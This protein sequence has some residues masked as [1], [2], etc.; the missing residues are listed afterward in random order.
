MS[1][2]VVVLNSAVT[3]NTL[4]DSRSHR[5]FGLLSSDGLFISVVVKVCV[6]LSGLLEFL[7]R[8]LLSVVAEEELLSL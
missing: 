3:L 1:A 6:W 8:H 2:F 5:L 7:G 4:C